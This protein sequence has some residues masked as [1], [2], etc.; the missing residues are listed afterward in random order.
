MA[1]IEVSELG[2]QWIQLMDEVTRT[3]SP[4]T[5]TNHGEAIAQLVPAGHRARTLIGL[6]KGQVT[7]HGDIH[8]PIGE[9][10]ESDA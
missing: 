4:L 1:T 2:S 8:A 6:H 10:S 7:V 5:I 3:G 9:D